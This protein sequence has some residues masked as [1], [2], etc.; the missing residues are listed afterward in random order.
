MKDEQCKRKIVK[1]SLLLKLEMAF[2]NSNT[3]KNTKYKHISPENCITLYKIKILYLWRTFSM[4][5]IL[6]NNQ[7][8]C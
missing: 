2:T 4:E 8:K 3:N 1:S 6:S 7:W 5:H